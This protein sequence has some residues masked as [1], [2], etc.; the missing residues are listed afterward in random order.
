M[1]I[2]QRNSEASSERKRINMIYSNQINDIIEA[3]IDALFSA[4]Y[5]RL[6]K[7]ELQV[8]TENRSLSSD[9]FAGFFFGGKLYT[10][11]DRTI[12]HK[13]IK[14]NLH[15][16]LVPSMERCQSDRKEVDFDR[17]R[18]K[19]ALALSLKD[20]RN[21]QDLRD[22]L[23]N[24]LA[25]MIDQIKGMDRMRPEAFTL[26]DEP[27]KYQQYRKLREKIEF[28]AAARLLY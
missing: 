21:N 7:Q 1:A 13:S 8:V 15:P 25:E 16:S 9:Q 4:E 20:V 3:L 28:Y 14:T 6:R 24:Q 27:R 23:P 11:L 10:D 19:Q 2:W 22:A 17:L 18:I 5:K 26:M 12:A